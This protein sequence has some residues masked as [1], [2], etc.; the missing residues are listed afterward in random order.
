[1]RQAMAVVYILLL[2]TTWHRACR[3]QLLRQRRR[4]ANATRQPGQ[5]K[6]PTVDN[7]QPTIGSRQRQKQTSETAGNDP[8]TTTAATTRSTATQTKCQELKS[9]MSPHSNKDKSKRRRFLFWN[10]QHRIQNMKHWSAYQMAVLSSLCYWNHLQPNTWPHRN[11]GSSPGFALVGQ[12]RLGGKRF[13]GELLNLQLCRVV[14][15]WQRFWSILTRRK[16]I[17]PARGPF[18][19]PCRQGF[20][21]RNDVLTLHYYFYDW[22]EPS[23]MLG[24]YHDTDLLLATTNQGRGTLIIAF[25]GTETVADTITN[26]QT[27]EPVTHAG[28]FG[29]NTADTSQNSTT[30]LLQGSIHRGFLNALTRV[31]RGWILRLE[32]ENTNNKLPSRVLR[33]IDRKYANCTNEILREQAFH[34]QDVNS[35]GDNVTIDGSDRMGPAESNGPSDNATRDRKRKRLG[36]RERNTRLIDILRRLVVDN[37]KAGRSVHLTGH[38][39]GGGLA[40]LLAMD[41]LIN[42]PNVP[43]QKLHLW[44]FG[45]PQVADEC[46]FES[47]MQ[48]VPRLRDFFSSHHHSHR[49]VTISDQCHEDIVSNVAQRALAPKRR[50]IFGKTFRKLGGVRGSV[51]HFN[52]PYYL[53][54][55]QQAVKEILETSVIEKHNDS[56]TRSAVSAHQVKN[57][58]SGISR[59]SDDH[60]LTTTL[61]EQV[62]KFI[63]EVV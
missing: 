50:N 25:A 39:L 5:K 32:R 4:Q 21:D 20:P 28:F 33:V 61:P 7:H 27:F 29:G 59:E 46:F 52:E 18:S 44:T 40:T 11:A 41:V 36:C 16:K 3:A 62:R 8:A 23:K 49:F 19:C 22:H 47:A 35:K 42:F 30:T 14:R 54:T 34:Q 12:R 1:M 57:Y 60:P 38:S 31:E 2:Q 53:M 13:L 17:A 9:K 26:V 58:L 55:P 43:V 15:L 45:A 24:N 51:V 37:L 10:G 63:G 56:S 48:L 6:T